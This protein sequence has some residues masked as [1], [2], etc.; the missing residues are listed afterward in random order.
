MS[1]KNSLLTPLSNRDL[2]QLYDSRFMCCVLGLDYDFSRKVGRVIMRELDCCD[3]VGCIK[4]FKAIDPGV[5]EIETFSGEKLDTV[6]RLGA[7]KK[8]TAH[9][10]IR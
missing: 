7:D 4:V 3:M 2:D 1:K 6:Y 10:P 9:Q 8:W 5:A